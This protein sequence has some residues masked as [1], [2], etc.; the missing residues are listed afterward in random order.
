MAT[1]PLAAAKRAAAT[2]SDI[3]E[4]PT[5]SEQAAEERAK[6][7]PSPG[8]DP[9]QPVAVPAPSPPV[10]QFPGEV[11]PEPITAQFPGEEPPYPAGYTPPMGEVTET[12]AQGKPTVI[13]TS[14][15]VDQYTP[16]S[17][18][19]K[20]GY[21][22]STDYAKTGALADNPMLAAEFIQIADSRGNPMMIK[23]TVVNRLFDLNTVDR[24]SALREMGV[25]KGETGGRIAKAI[26]AM[27]PYVVR[28]DLAK[29]P[30]ELP[31]VTGYRLE[32]AVLAGIA[33]DLLV[34]LFGREEVRNAKIYIRAAAAS[35]AALSPY[36]KKDGSVDIVAAA[37]AVR[38]KKKGVREA[39]LAMGYNGKEIDDLVSVLTKNIVLNGRMMPLKSE[40]DKDGTITV[41]GWNDLPEKYQSIALKN[42]LVV[43]E[44][45]LT[46][47][48]DE[49]VGAMTMLQDD[50]NAYIASS[51]EEKFNILLA[52]GA[53]P[54]G[55]TFAGV[56]VDGEPTYFLQGEGA[57]DSV[58]TII[59]ESVIPFLYVA[60]HYKEMKILPTVSEIWSDHVTGKTYT[61]EERAQLISDYDADVA[62]LR[63]QAS[64]TFESDPQK[65]FDAQ[66]KLAELQSIGRPEDRLGRDIANMTNSIAG[67]LALDILVMLP[68]IGWLGKTGAVSARTATG[69]S[70][71]ARAVQASRSML[72]AAK[73]IPKGMLW[74]F[75]KG[76]VTRPVKTL[77]GLAEITVE[78]IVH[79]I[80]TARNVA[81]IFTGKVQLGNFIPVGTVTT[82]S[83]LGRAIPLRTVTGQMLNVSTPSPSDML[84]PVAVEPSRQYA[85]LEKANKLPQVTYYEQ[86]TVDPITRNLTPEEFEILKILGVRPGAEGRVVG[87]KSGVHPLTGEPISP[88]ATAMYQAQAIK[89][90]AQLHGYRAA[91]ARFGIKQVSAV[92]PE[93]KVYVKAE[94]K[95]EQVMAPERAASNKRTAEKVTE[96]VYETLSAE[97]ISPAEYDTMRL[98]GFPEE[99][100]IVTEA[101]PTLGRPQTE[102][103]LK[104]TVGG[105]GELSTLAGRGYLQTPDP[106][107][108]E[109]VYPGREAA[110]AEMARTPLLFTVMP[111]GAWMAVPKA[112]VSIANLQLKY[113][114]YISDPQMVAEIWARRAGTLKAY[115]EMASQAGSEEEFLKLVKAGMI[116]EP[117]EISTVEVPRKFGTI[118]TKVPMPVDPIMN[119]YPVTE[120]VSILSATSNRAAVASRKVRNVAG[121]GE[122]ATVEKTFDDMTEAER[123]LLRGY[124]NTIQEIADIPG[125]NF[126]EKAG[127]L[128]VNIIGFVDE[129]GWSAAIDKFGLTVVLAIY[130][131]ALE[132]ALYE[133]YED[134]QRLGTL[135]PEIMDRFTKVVGSDVV[136]DSLSQFSPERR[137][138]I[139]KSFRSATGGVTVGED[140]R[141]LTEPGQ[142][143][144]TT[145]LLGAGDPG[146]IDLILGMLSEPGEELVPATAPGTRRARPSAVAE[147][148]PEASRALPISVTPETEIGEVSRIGALERVSPFIAPTT[149]P[150]PHRRPSVAPTPAGKPTPVPTPMI[151]S[152]D[153][154]V[155]V[156]VTVPVPVPTPVP[157][158][159][160]TPVP[161]PAP[162]PAP[163]PI[164][165]TAPIPVPVPVPTPVPVPVPTPVPITTLTPIPIPLPIPVP[166]P[167]LLPVD[168]S[169]AVK[170]KYSR[171]EITGYV[172]FNMGWQ[173]YGILSPFTQKDLVNLGQLK[174]NDPAAK[175]SP[176][177]SLIIVGKPPGRSISFDLG[178][179]D[180]YIDV[181][182]KKI[183][184]SGDGE[185]TDVGESDPSTTKGTSIPGTSVAGHKAKYAVGKK[186]TPKKTTGRATG[187]T[188]YM[189]GESFAI[190]E[191]TGL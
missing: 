108:L 55:S 62:V 107:H 69:V 83:T 84:W 112:G 32:E 168:T 125:E 102:Y 46:K 49:T 172:L 66:V 87:S 99:R 127:W 75:P 155:P 187:K 13:R 135:H 136:Q 180:G 113:P 116:A 177:E 88:E 30:G 77:G 20:M 128:M 101:E 159:V 90:E 94:A 114:V 24:N 2:S 105:A 150:R 173:K 145:A 154:P 16:N 132:M 36:L 8:E 124:E 147:R 98:Q 22:T 74:D 47:D 86:M 100:F 131:Y 95:M 26:D 160:S 50:Y 43:A 33:T 130:P 164:P 65:R 23:K 21:L 61:S 162:A 6:A 158:P 14:A 148:T 80:R 178:I 175:V 60:R 97:R 163:V 138:E 167:V 72:F 29:F 126:D 81:G 165:V 191:I 42:G 121:F 17:T 56:G 44:N 92:F 140:A 141:V 40:R 123:D 134:M 93:V 182:G 3:G 161:A 25:V 76:L 137:E 152:V 144:Q 53:L 15:G 109:V 142:V 34:A 185:S 184:F 189:D 139:L 35:V 156:P 39:L 157:V 28:D 45:R 120:L 169:S 7:D 58:S 188:T 68:L 38:L 106:H 51:P 63:R 31:P 85:I 171:G 78:P 179:T 48:I 71:L 96:F 103:Y 9:E 153:V 149:A 119:L 166:P 190:G 11:P 151:S 174:R 18:M 176:Q 129:A 170:D 27:R 41:I 186:K 143:V 70:R 146:Q 57:G 115:G 59:A 122:P 54:V 5:E 181:R 133:E 183:H 12:D 37:N 64:V 1:N 73:A 118:Q 10:D 67:A 91:V 82:T 4:V 111:G 19:Y 52:A 79:P 104:G 110:I 89:W 117:T